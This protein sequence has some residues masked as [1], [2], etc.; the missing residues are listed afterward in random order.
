[1]FIII[2]IFNLFLKPT[3]VIPFEHLPYLNIFQLKINVHGRLVVSTHFPPFYGTHPAPVASRYTCTTGKVIFYHQSP[4]EGSNHGLPYIYA[5]R[6]G[7]GSNSL[8][9]VCTDR[10]QHKALYIQTIYTMT[11][12]LVIL[13]D[14]ANSLLLF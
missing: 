10:C 2:P 9:S 5:H 11:N 7:H 14:L 8:L 1:M 12:E 6:E 4:P 13:R 3:L